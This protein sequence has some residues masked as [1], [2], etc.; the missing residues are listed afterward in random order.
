MTFFSWLH[1]SLSILFYTITPII[2]AFWLALA[3]DL[4][5]N[6]RTMRSSLQSFPRCFKMAE[7]FESFA[8]L[9]QTISINSM[10]SI[11]K[12]NIADT[13]RIEQIK[14][15]CLFF[16]ILVR[17]IAS[18][19]ACAKTVL[20]HLNHD[21]RSRSRIYETMTAKKKKRNKV[22]MTL[23]KIQVT[24][25][26][27]KQDMQRKSFIQIHWDLNGVA[28]LVPPQMGTNMAAGN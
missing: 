19:R 25:V 11:V 2:L 21:E 27:L 14:W 18:V 6:K 24:V 1:H 9:A 10:R 20:G 3:Y 7:C 13:T 15:S 22:N 23:A 5:E 12:K 17:W 8:W 28:M 16:A 26:F 4:L